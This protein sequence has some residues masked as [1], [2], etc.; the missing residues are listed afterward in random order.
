MC[1][2]HLFEI[3]PWW[4]LFIPIPARVRS[5]S[6]KKKKK[7]KYMV[8]VVFKGISCFLFL[9]LLSGHI[10]SRIEKGEGA[11]KRGCK[12]IFYPTGLRYASVVFGAHK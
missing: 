5:F 2:Q 1:F 3:T 7:P 6:G 9:F 8:A 11:G 10:S 12:G 4:P